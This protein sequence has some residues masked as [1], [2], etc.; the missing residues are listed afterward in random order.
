MKIYNQNKMIKIIADDNTFKI[1]QVEYESD[2]FKKTIE[3]KVL[4]TTNATDENNVGTILED[5]R[6]KGT[7]SND[8][9]A[10]KKSILENFICKNTKPFDPFSA[11]GVICIF[12][13]D[14][15]RRELLSK[16][17]DK[18]TSEIQNITDIDYSDKFSKKDKTKSIKKDK[19]TG[20]D[21]ELSINVSIPFKNLLIIDDVIDEGDTL[22]I[23]LDKLLSQ[24]LINNETTIKMGCIYNRPKMNK[25]TFNYKDII[26]K[27]SEKPSH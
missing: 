9:F 6:N 13:N 3:I 22:V 24:N 1:V 5:Y 25:P 12:P 10:S 15:N 17:K 7:D 11:D 21:F 20:L 19:L 27:R 23:L 26:N 18:L 8:F 4:T 2:D 16:F 14:N